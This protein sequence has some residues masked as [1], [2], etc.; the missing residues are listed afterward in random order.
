[1]TGKQQLPVPVRNIAYWQKLLVSKRVLS[2]QDETHK[3]SLLIKIPCWPKKFWFIFSSYLPNRNH[4]NMPDVSIW[5]HERKVKWSTLISPRVA[6]NLHESERLTCNSLTIIKQRSLSNP[7]RP[8]V[9]R[10]VWISEKRRLLVT[11]WWV[12]ISYQVFSWSMWHVILKQKE[13]KLKTQSHFKIHPKEMWDATGFGHHIWGTTVTGF[14]FN[15]L[16]A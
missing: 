6:G 11:S 12:F 16:C 4:I 10:V 3:N 9:P 8:K 14:V 5:K 15:N 13:T 1:M 2:S 7:F